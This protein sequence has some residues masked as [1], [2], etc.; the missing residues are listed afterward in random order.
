MSGAICCACRITRPLETLLAVTDRATGSVR[1]VC[2][3]S[4]PQTRGR[5]CFSDAVRTADLDAIAQANSP[6]RRADARRERREGERAR[7]RELVAQR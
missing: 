7:V 4:L 3:P 1:F 2:R 6:D 5:A